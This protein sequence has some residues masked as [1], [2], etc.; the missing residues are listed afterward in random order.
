M[1]SLQLRRRIIGGLGVGL[2]ALVGYR[3][4]DPVPGSESGIAVVVAATLLLAGIVRGAL[5]VDPHQRDLEQ[6]KSYRLT[7]RSVLATTAVT[8][9]AMLAGVLF[10]GAVLGAVMTTAGYESLSYA[11]LADV[12]VRLSVLL[13]LPTV[14]LVLLYA[15]SVVAAGTG[16]WLLYPFVPGEDE[17][18]LGPVIFV[19]VWLELGAVA[20]MLSPGLMPEPAAI[21]LDAALVA[22]WGHFFAVAYEDVQAYVP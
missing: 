3:I 15:G 1:G 21:A 5:R 9:V 18:R 2:A 13:Q 14:D 11:I 12:L 17:E 6:K 20:L 22:L 16:F 10:A 19:I 8:G 7:Y 4:L